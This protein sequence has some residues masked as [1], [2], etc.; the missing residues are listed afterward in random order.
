VF[1]S[2]SGAG[3]TTNLV[4]VERRAPMATTFGKVLHTHRTRDEID[5]PS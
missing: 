1:V 4:T 3:L 2:A 5:R